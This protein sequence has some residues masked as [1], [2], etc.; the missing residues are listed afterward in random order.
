MN[1]EIAFIL[2]NGITRLQ[3]NCEN[4]LDIGLVYG[5]N[6]IY[7]EFS[8]TVLVSTDKEM[9]TEIQNNGY[10]SR[11]VHYT[12]KNNKIAK[13]GSN[14]LPAHL[15]SLSS[16]PAALGLA[17]ES[18][19]NYLYMIGMDLK[20]INNKINNIYAGT[21]NYKDKDSIPTHFDN[22][23]SQIDTIIKKA[24]LKRFIQVNPLSGFTPDVWIKNDN[25]EIMNINEFKRLINNTHNRISS[26]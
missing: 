9:A 23:I 13:S 5:C 19:A 1:K 22:W 10:S 17:S 25:F 11:N 12:R 8:P 15:W 18:S 24:E 3:V 14:I 16:G 7:Q 2:G 26:S 20:G 4:L 6:R 21:A